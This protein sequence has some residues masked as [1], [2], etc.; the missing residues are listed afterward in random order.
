MPLCGV[1][2]FEKEFRRTI[3][4]YAAAADRTTLPQLEYLEK[5]RKDYAYKV[6]PV[7]VK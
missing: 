4:C 2:L 1:V 5:K 3:Y 6:T 7:C